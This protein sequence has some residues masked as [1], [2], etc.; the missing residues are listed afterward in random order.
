MRKSLAILYLT[1][2]T[3]AASAQAWAPPYCVGPNYALQFSS[4]GWLCAVITGTPGPAGP[5][6]PA[7]PPGPVGPS[8][9]AAPPTTECITAHWNGTTW[10]CVPTNYLTAQ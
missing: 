1:L 6:G 9:P 10:T 3:S 5:V 2:S 4:Q 8:M 7:G